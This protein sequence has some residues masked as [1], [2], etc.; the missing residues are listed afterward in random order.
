MKTTNYDWVEKFHQCYIKAMAKYQK[1][2][3]RPATYFNAG[4]TAFLASIGCT[5]QELYDFAED[6]CTTQEL[7]FATVVLITSV[8]R[9]FFRVVQK[10]KRSRRTISTADL[11]AKDAEV[12]GFVWLPRIIA[13]ARAKLRGEMPPDLMF[14]CGGDRPF[15]KKVDIH[16]ADFLREVWA[17]R[18]DDRKIIEYVKKHVAAAGE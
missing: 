12:D 16:P 5:A 15:L 11:P 2:N 13:K 17:A 18:D 14:G 4:E 6:W 9:D 7:S 10:G 8:R 1:G 3:R